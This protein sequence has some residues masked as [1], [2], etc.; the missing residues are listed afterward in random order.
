MRYEE[1]DPEEQHCQRDGDTSATS[2]QQD[3]LAV[4]NIEDS[5]WGTPTVSAAGATAPSSSSSGSDSAYDSS[6][7]TD[8]STRD[9]TG[10]GRKGA[11]TAADRDRK[12]LI[13]Q[14]AEGQAQLRGCLDEHRDAVGRLIERMET[15]KAHCTSTEMANTRLS[16]ELAWLCMDTLAVDAA[17]AQKGA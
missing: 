3:L 4:K 5:G 6:D 9:R 17:S 8:A 13:G 10:K 14:V 15:L 11:K 1:P 7:S 2:G 16:S 12:F